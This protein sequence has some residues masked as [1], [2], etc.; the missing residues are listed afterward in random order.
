M[1][2]TTLVESRIVIPRVGCYKLYYRKTVNASIVLNM[3]SK[4]GTLNGLMT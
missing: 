1:S 4:L 2:Q 3:V